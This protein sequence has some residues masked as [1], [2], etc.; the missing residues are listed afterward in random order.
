MISAAKDCVVR[1]THIELH[2]MQPT[3]KTPAEIYRQLPQAERHAMI[4]AMYT[5]HGSQKDIAAAL[6]IN[7]STVSRVLD[8]MLPDR[9]SA[10]VPTAAVAFDGMA[11]AVAYK[12]AHDAIS[13]LDAPTRA[14]VVKRLAKAFRQP[15]AATKA[16]TGPKSRQDRVQPK[17]TARAGR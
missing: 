16:K 4:A 9:G 14:A 12:H 6:N 3:P 13:R 7:A 5:N 1:K 8:Q 2:P 15:P 17:K 10:T 11:E